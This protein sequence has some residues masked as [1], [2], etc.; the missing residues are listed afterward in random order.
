MFQG[1]CPNVSSVNDFKKSY[2]GNK[3]KKKLLKNDYQGFFNVLNKLSFRKGCCVCKANND[4]KT[5]QEF[6]L[7]GH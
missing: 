6:Y 3:A 2:S 7:N 4:R 1:H 5:G